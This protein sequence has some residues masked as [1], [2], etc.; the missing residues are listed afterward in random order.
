MT[1]DAD[2]GAL[3][4]LVDALRPDSMAHARQV[5]EPL[6]DPVLL[7]LLTAPA[8]DEELS[9]EEVAALD[10]IEAERAAGTSITYVTDEDLARRIGG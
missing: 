7:A 4:T 10:A 8:E 9:D 2:R 5:L 1:I 6:V 3:H